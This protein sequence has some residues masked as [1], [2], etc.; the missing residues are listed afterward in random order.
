MPKSFLALKLLPRIKALL[1][2]V[3]SE[4]K[5]FIFT[6]IFIKTEERKKRIYS[7]T[8]K[9]WIHVIFCYNSSLC[10]PFCLIFGK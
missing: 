10:L 7:D 8:H 2:F 5:D 6:Y 4:L 3:K 9:Y 1:L